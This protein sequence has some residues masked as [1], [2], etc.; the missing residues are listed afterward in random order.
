M[1][2]SEQRQAVREKSRERIPAASH[3]IMERSVD[4][5][6]S[7]VRRPPRWTMHPFWRQ[8]I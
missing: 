3:S 5:L 2:L 4:D 8:A 7:N 6:R 1:V